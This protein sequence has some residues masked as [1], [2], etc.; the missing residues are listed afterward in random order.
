[1]KNWMSCKS[2]FNRKE[3]CVLCF[4]FLQRKWVWR[5]F[6]YESK[7]SSCHASPIMPS[8]VTPINLILL[9]FLLLFLFYYYYLLII[10][11]IPYLPIITII[12][13]YLLVVTIVISAIVIVLLLSTDRYYY[14][15]YLL[16][17][18]YELLLPASNRTI[19]KTSQ[20]QILALLRSAFV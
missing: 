15:C 8:H 7:V 19:R 3:E 1:M 10:T 14:H 11:I 16:I 9:L 18:Y 13:Y 2:K 17:I 5:C 6:G 20:F 4:V 12:T